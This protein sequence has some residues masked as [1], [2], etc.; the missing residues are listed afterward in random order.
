MAETN[1][2]ADTH[3]RKRFIRS[4]SRKNL[5]VASALVAELGLTSACGSDGNPGSPT[6]PNPNAPRVAALSPGTPKASAASQTITVS[7]ERFATGLTFLLDNPSGVWTTYSGSAINVQSPTTFTATVML[8]KT[9]TWDITVH[10][11]DGL[12]SNEMQFSV[13]P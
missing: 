7:G 10:S 3:E 2:K 1:Q 6:P 4:I 8:D 9:G 13:V 11:A 5:L 12:E